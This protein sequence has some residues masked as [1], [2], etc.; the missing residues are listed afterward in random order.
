M[1]DLVTRLQA[2]VRQQVKPNAV[3]Q[4]VDKLDEQIR[5]ALQVFAALSKLEDAGTSFAPS[6][7]VCCVDDPLS[8][9]LNLNLMSQLQELR[10]GSLALKFA[11]ASRSGE[12]SLEIA[13]SFMETS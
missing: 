7:L 11:E 10:S 9:A 13:D 5:S 12:E 4:E 8:L 1:D 3:K 2:I 6:T